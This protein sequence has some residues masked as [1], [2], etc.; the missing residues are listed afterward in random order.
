L[1]VAAVAFFDVV[2]VSAED[3]AC[4]Q[5]LLSAKRTVSNADIFIVYGRDIEARLQLSRYVLGSGRNE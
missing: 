5:T 3:L 4:E 1:R 2:R